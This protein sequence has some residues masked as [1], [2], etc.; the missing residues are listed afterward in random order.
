MKTR[1]LELSGTAQLQSLPVADASWFLEFA[2]ALKARRRK[3]PAA[4]SER[5]GSKNARRRRKEMW[6]TTAEQVAHGRRYF[7]DS[8]VAYFSNSNVLI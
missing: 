1:A 7:R 2:H 4:H 3:D 6:K 8:E 5:R